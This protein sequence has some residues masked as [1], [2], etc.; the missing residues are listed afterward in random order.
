MAINLN[1]VTNTL[2]ADTGNITL[3]STPVVFSAYP[4]VTQSILASSYTKILFQATEVN[5]NS[6]YNSATSQFLPLV[7]GYYQVNAAVAFAGA[8]SEGYIQIR[9]NGSSI[10]NGTDVG[11]TSYNTIVSAIVYLNGSTDY[12]EIYGYSGTALN[13][14][15]SAATSYFQACQLSAPGNVGAVMAFGAGYLNIPQN[16]QSNAYTTVASDSGYH[17]FHPVTDTTARIYTI[18]ANTSVAYAI[19]TTLTFVNMSPSLVTI[20]I[21]TD[22]LYHAATGQTGSRTL[23]Q[24]GMA[25]AMKLTSTTWIISGA[26]LT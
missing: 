23:A 26:G 22:T 15:A 12:L 2:S 11:G 19:G 14:S 8:S 13:I 9:K 3:V 25:T 17:I 1:H 7:A 18:P 24:Y 20:A 10:K 21:T 6:Y 4:N 16:I 5:I